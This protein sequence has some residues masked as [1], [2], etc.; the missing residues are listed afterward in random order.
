MQNQQQAQKQ[1]RNY[2]QLEYTE[3]IQP[4]KVW[5]LDLWAGL[6]HLQR[7]FQMNWLSNWFSSEPSIRETTDASGKTHWHIYD[8]MSDRTLQFDTEH[9]VFIWLEERHHRRSSFSSFDSW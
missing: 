5:R 2:Q 3:S 7:A 8:P 9:E 1:W 6:R 4:N